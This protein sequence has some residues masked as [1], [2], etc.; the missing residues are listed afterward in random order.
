M[1]Q[2]FHTGNFDDPAC[3]EV[4]G[5]D[6]F[7]GVGVW[8]KMSPSQAT[9]LSVHVESVLKRAR[10]L[11]MARLI[12]TQAGKIKKISPVNFR[13]FAKE[14]DPWL[15]YASPL[16]RMY[17][18]DVLQ[19]YSISRFIWSLRGISKAETDI[20]WWIYLPKGPL[21]WAIYNEPRTTSIPDLAV[22]AIQYIKDSRKRLQFAPKD[23]PNI[24]KILA[25]YTQPILEF[26]MINNDGS[27]DDGKV[28]TKY[29]YCP[30]MGTLSFLH[31]AERVG[32]DGK[33]LLPMNKEFVQGNQS[34]SGA[35]FKPYFLEP[36][37]G[38]P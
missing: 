38:T 20:M 28:R 34:T 15:I 11:G 31:L 26:G 4:K 8:T 32:F 3:N 18:D 17:D 30:A 6:P 29:R 27:P 36:A 2:G 14:D 5:G 22:K 7:R 12:I 23:Q 35:G 37:G 13:N 9:Q 1:G 16:L 33:I 10:P 24:P 19:N 21:A 25:E